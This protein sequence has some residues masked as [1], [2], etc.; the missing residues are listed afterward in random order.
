MA[1]TSFSALADRLR[2]AEPLAE[3]QLAAAEQR[4]GQAYPPSFRTL[5]LEHG[6]FA[7][8]R[9]GS[10][11][12]TVF[13]VWPLEEHQTALARAAGELECDATAEA[14]AGELGLPE[15]TIAVLDQIV[16]IG[17]EHDEDFVGFDLRTRAGSGEATFVLQLMDDTEIEYL[18]EHPG[19][20][21][22]GFDAWLERHVRRNA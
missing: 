17:C 7:L 16:L 18:A 22:P 6:P 19:A 5:L 1:T 3:A 13:R 21:A 10:P 15:E 4:L 11:E 14:V 20:D 2:A 12:S 8:H 9:A